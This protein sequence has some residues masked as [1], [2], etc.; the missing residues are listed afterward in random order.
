MK[1]NDTLECKTVRPTLPTLGKWTKVSIEGKQNPVYLK[2]AV[3]IQN[4]K[5]ISGYVV[6][7]EAEP[8]IV[9]G[10]HVLHLIELGVGVTITP[11]IVDHTYGDLRPYY[12]CV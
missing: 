2:N 6:T 1:K 5:F 4:Y 8:V 3:Y 9:K 10:G 12:S 11:M 7:K